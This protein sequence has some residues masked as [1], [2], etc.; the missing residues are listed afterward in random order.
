MQRWNHEHEGRR[1]SMQVQY[2]CVGALFR[3]DMENADDIRLNAALFKVCL[4]DKRRFCPDVFPGNGRAQICLE[5]H[6]D[7]PDFTTECKCAPAS[8]SDYPLPV[9]ACVEEPISLRTHPTRTQSTDERR[10]GTPL[11]QP[12]ADVALRRGTAQR[13]HASCLCP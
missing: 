9:D 10:S 11:A 1:L 12:D 13:G 8:P 6:M 2:D 7:K 3:M 4:N 5:E